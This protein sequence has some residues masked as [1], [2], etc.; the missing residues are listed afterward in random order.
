MKKIYPLY[1]IRYP[2]SFFVLILLLGGCGSQYSAEKLYWQ[3][4]QASKE[5]AKGR[6]LD[7]LNGQEYEKIISGYRRLV[8]RFP[9]ES[10][11]AQSQFIITQIYILRKQY[12][13]AEEE[14]VKVI[15]NFSNNPELASQAQFMIGNLYERQGKQKK[16]I[17]EY[18]KISNL[19]PLSRIGLKVPVY[20]AEYYQRDKNE[21][22][23]VKA[24]D[25]AI[26]YYKRLINEYSGT[27]F[28]AVLKDFLALA[29][30]SQGSWDKAVDVWQT[31]VDENPQDQV[32]ENLLFTLG[33]TYLRQIKDLQ[34]AIDTYEDF[35][36]KNPNSKIIKYA[37][38]QIGRL[39][40]IKED[41][42]SAIKIFKE[43]IENYPKEIKLCAD[44]KLAIAACYEKQ[45]D[46]EGVMRVYAE[47][48][49]AYPDTSTALSIP[50]FIAKHYQKEKQPVEAESAF[51]EAI[52][53]YEKIIKQN[54]NS[55]QA[56]QAQDL[57]S[58][59]Y[60]SQ[61]KWDKAVD[62]LRVL[63][64]TYSNNPRA[65]KAMFTVAII[66]RRQLH[67]PKLAKEIFEKF[68]QQYPGHELASLAKSEIESL[69]GA[70]TP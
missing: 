64:E 41:F 49:A 50:L 47:I 7:K 10:V 13:Q 28:S 6:P 31:I 56:A 18:E 61:Q 26:K 20:I 32:G 30:V 25:K 57:I 51:K 63:V 68:I 66:Y 3:A 4:N 70:L 46:W 14:L 65:P 48:K 45:G 12:P 52:S 40:L 62:S 11:S 23:A 24:Y 21:V 5:I 9:L 1:A 39:Y 42:P 37:K 43:I 44:A 27:S 59:G 22:E 36:S 38:F 35:V 16:A 67:K 58:L 33:E 54:P 15:Q 34:K 2:L 17:L 53:G 8:G 55:P 29:Y 69:Q 60:L 19:Y